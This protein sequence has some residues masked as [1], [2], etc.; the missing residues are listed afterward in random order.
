[1][2]A[3]SPAARR[4]R[5]E[6]Q[7]LLKYNNTQIAVA[8]SC[9]SCLEWHFLLHSLP[10]STAYEKGLY[11]G[12]LVFPEQFPNYPPAL[13]MFTP[14]GR[15]DVGKRICMSMTDF[16]PE[17]WNPAWTMQSLLVGVISFMLDEA[18]DDSVG[19]LQS[20]AD[21]RKK[22]AL[23]SSNFNLA[24]S[25]FCTHF[26]DWAESSRCSESQVCSSVVKV[27][28]PEVKLNPEVVG[29]S[30]CAKKTDALELGTGVKSAMTE[31]TNVC[32]ICHE[33]GSEILIHPCACRGSMSGVHASCVQSWVN[34]SRKHSV[35]GEF[36][37]CA[38]CNQAYSGK[39]SRPGLRDFLRQGVKHVVD[40]TV[41][42]VYWIASQPSVPLNARIFAGVFS[43][44]FLVYRSVR[45]SIL[46]LNAPLPNTGLPVVHSAN[47][48]LSEHKRDAG[49]RLFVVS[50]WY[51]AGRMSFD[52]VVAMLVICSIPVFV[53]V[54]KQ[55]DI[56]PS[57][58]LLCRLFEAI[59]ARTR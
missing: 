4:L 50:L 29:A 51:S 56:L 57:T 37:K 46:L 44:G 8:P 6:Y 28:L 49:S 32:W 9:D 33:A 25:D 3:A 1:M 31:E 26:P 12:K 14:S 24:N 42:L 48:P 2:S 10:S 16:H 23:A 43:F 11:H 20:S 21:V 15:F 30:Q 41:L 17:S 34:H 59:I 54:V 7:D 36:P 55:H 45:L 27:T 47:L 13:I 52:F 40:A 19:S 5:R 22:L 38:V 58:A 39:D 35:D 53:A 18:G